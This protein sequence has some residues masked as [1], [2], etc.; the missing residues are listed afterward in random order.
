MRDRPVNLPASISARLRIIARAK[1]VNPELILRRYA[2]ERLLSRLSLS[3]YHDRFILKGAMLF[4]VWLA[5]PY[6]PTQDLD[7]LGFG[8]AAVQ[9]I[10]TT[11]RAICRQDIPGDGLIFD[12]D[13][14]IAE[15][16]REDQQY[17]G[18]RVRTRALLGRA[19][20][21]IQVDVGFG[22]VITPAP[23]EIEFPSLLH[24]NGPRLKA[25]PRETVV[26]EKFQA[27]VALGIA[28]SRM[29]DFYDLLALSRLFSF[30]G[31]SL[32]TA[33]RATFDR[34]QTSIPSR[35]PTGLG[36]TFAS[37]RQKIAQWTAFLGREPLLVEAGGLTGTIDAIAGF[38][39]PPAQAARTGRDFAMTWNP[40]GPWHAMPRI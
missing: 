21:P 3:P 32:A 30:D 33:I 31:L 38:V 22:D 6:R 12:A 11:F 26:A 15:A 4:T 29:K 13:G 1:Q 37:D 20:I 9:S 25:Y 7:L 18:V 35:R 27:I 19:R 16:I 2:L 36:R 14:L 28:N 5:D 10:A 17:G 24:P 23:S 34:R 39:M 40:T 8:D